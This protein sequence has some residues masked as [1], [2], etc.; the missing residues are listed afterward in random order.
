MVEAHRAINYRR[1]DSMEDLQ[2]LVELEQQ[3]LEYY[4]EADYSGVVCTITKA[5]EG[6]GLHTKIVPKDRSYLIH[7][8]T[9]PITGPISEWMVTVR[10]YKVGSMQRAIDMLL[11]GCNQL[12]EYHVCKDSELVGQPCTIRGVVATVQA[13][14]LE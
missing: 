12:P 5:M 4:K 8:A 2:Q 6:V 3:A 10:V 7:V 14:L 13:C 9:E 11:L 1:G